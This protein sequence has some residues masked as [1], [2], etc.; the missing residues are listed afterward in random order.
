MKRIA[1]SL[2][3]L[4]I[5]LAACSSGGP[6]TSPD[7]GGSND[8]GDIEHPTGSDEAIFI[9]DMTG[10]FV[11]VEFMTTH[12][13]PFVLLGDGRVIV[14]GAQTLQFP[15]PALPAL[16]ER[17]LTEEGIQTVLRAIGDTDLFRTDLDLRGAANT[18]ADA[19]DTV[20]ILD[21]GG[22]VVTVSVYGLGTLSPAQGQA[23]PGVSSAEMEA[24]GVLQQLYERMLALESWVPAD[25]WEGEGWRPYEPEAFRLYVRD[26]TGEPQE[27]GDMPEQVREW[28]TDADPAAFGEEQ[29]TFGNGTRCGVVE[30]EEAATWLEALSSANQLTLWA[31]SADPDARFSVLARPLL[32]HEE[33]T[34]PELIGA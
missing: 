20:F 9:I 17:T 25:A 34:C 10:G 16:M 8:A 2:L 31:P 22:Q 13:P 27:R 23:P 24:H 21:A 15:G 12:F 32:P 14:Q 5:L 3:I 1:L 26:V 18:V 7:P 33:A 11:P 6:G 19:S 28:P 30:G 4:A 29:A